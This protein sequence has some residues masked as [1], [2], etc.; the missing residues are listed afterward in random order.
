MT[1]FVSILAYLL[2]PLLKLNPLV[3]VL[4]TLLGAGVIYFCILLL[5][6]ENIIY[7]FIKGENAK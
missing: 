3:N 6:K 7:S 1:I 5:L 4:I 2:V